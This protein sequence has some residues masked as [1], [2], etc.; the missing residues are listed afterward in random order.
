MGVKSGTSLREQI[1][2][3]YIKKYYPDTVNRFQH[4]QVGEIDIF[5][6]NQKVGIEYDGSYWHKKKLDL[7]NQKNIKAKEAGLRLIR[8]REYTLPATEQPFGE[9]YLP[10]RSMRIYDMNH[11][12]VILNGLGSL[13][14]NKELEDLTVT[15]EELKK[16]LSEVYSWTY[17]KPVSPNLTDMCGVELWDYELNGN[18]KPENI[19]KEEWA[20]ALL[21]CPNNELIELPRYKRDYKENCKEGRKRGCEECVGH[22][23]CP[24]IQWCRGNQYE[25]GLAYDCKIVEKQVR[26]LIKKG[27]WIF[28]LEK[29]SYLS[30]W[31][32]LKSN[33]GMKLVEEIL[34]I[35]IDDKRRENYYKFLGI[36]YKD[37]GF[38]SSTNISVK[39]ELDKALV[40]KLAEQLKYVKLTATINP[41]INTGD[42]Y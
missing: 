7:D 15:E 4:E 31:I 41:N 42:Y 39:N 13:L 40:E 1:L 5:I 19:P 27:T 24:F 23:V 28:D 25:K 12:N 3:K 10:K 9:I 21:R 6:P 32:W 38:V 20:Y 2:F 33:L 34:D 16:E 18:L 22:L 11:L 36:R 17:D 14:D 26:K 30:D 29:G 37:I 35:P 8:I